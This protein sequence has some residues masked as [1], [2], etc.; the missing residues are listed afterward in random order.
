MS[1]GAQ[2]PTPDTPPKSKP[3]PQLKPKQLTYRPHRIAIQGSKDPWPRPSPARPI[4]FKTHTPT[5]TRPYQ[6]SAALPPASM[7]LDLHLPGLS[8]QYLPMATALNTPHAPRASKH[9]STEAPNDAVASPVTGHLTHGC[10][11]QRR[12]AQAQI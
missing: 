9:R 7:D 6:R 2:T 10:Q 8:G 3:K 1:A 4:K 11:R 12:Q 5:D